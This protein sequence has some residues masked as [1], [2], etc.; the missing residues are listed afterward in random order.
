MNSTRRQRPLLGTFV[1]IGVLM[2]GAQAHAAIEAGFD[3]VAAIERLLSFHNPRS[4]LSRLNA[5][6]GVELRLSP[7]SLRVLR[8]A[9]AM[10]RASAGLFDCT[11]G[12]E[13]VR[14]AALPDHGGPPPLP[15]G[16][17]DDVVFAPGRVRLRRPLRITLDGIAKGYAVDRAIACL[18]HRGVSA[19]WV[20][21]GGDLR[22]FGAT[23]VPIT[24]RELDGRRSS[25]GYL[26][27]AAVASS[28]VTTERDAYRPGVIVAGSKG[29]QQPGMWSVLARW[30]WRADA[31]TKVA[32]LAPA[33]LRQ[34]LIASLGG[35]LL[36]PA[37]AEP[38]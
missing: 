27:N 24:R 37:T 18:R 21:A 20:N 2:H 31:L 26:Q 34:T 13:L 19:G 25:L 35:A 12:G 36:T 5:T 11:V 17:V 30:A 29:S 33:A 6:P 8:L 14:L 4:E 1:E 38:R 3:T 16:E 7:D 22:A 28:A 15:H 23:S 10:M 32:A 9:M